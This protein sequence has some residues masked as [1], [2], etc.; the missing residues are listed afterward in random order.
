[1]S[2]DPRAIGPLYCETPLAAFSFPA[3]PVNFFTNAVIV[4][5]GLIAFYLSYRQKGRYDVWAL[6]TLLTLTGI[7]SFLWHGLRTP[8]SLTLDVVPGLMFLLLFVFVWA[9]RI[10][11]TYRS[12]FF[13][14]GFLV[15]TMGLSYLTQ[16]IV[17]YR[18]PPIGVVLA[19]IGASAYL[20]VKTRAQ[21]GVV[22]WWGV[23]SVLLSLV[24][25]FFR[26]IDLYTCSVI[27]FGTHFLWHMFLS[28]GAF[29]GILLILEID[30]LSAGHSKAK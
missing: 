6:A 29:V 8:L 17:P 16:L 20:I 27:P 4:A 9:R 7:G 1:V 21:Y 2:V 13:L 5:F 19:V 26:S 28:G 23:A 22:A 25:Y 15:A 30:R 12:L 10:W 3:E 18:G 24:A 11:G 14:F